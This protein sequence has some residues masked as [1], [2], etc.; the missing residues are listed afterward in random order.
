M[1][2]SQLLRFV[3]LLVVG[4]GF[5]SVSTAEPDKCPQS[6]IQEQANRDK[7]A[8]DRDARM[9]KCR[10]GERRD[11][12]VCELNAREKLNLCLFNDVYCKVRG[13]PSCD[14]P[15]PKAKP[16]TAVQQLE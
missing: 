11:R 15:R 1:V 13:F 6:C 7:C 12:D 10:F 3:L 14:G 16:E 9:E 5:S 4:V 8:A 2:M